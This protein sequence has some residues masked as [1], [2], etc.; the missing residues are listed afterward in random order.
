MISS[1]PFYFDLT[2]YQT[3]WLDFE[4]VENKLI[5]LSEIQLEEVKRLKKRNDQGHLYPK[6]TL[7][8]ALYIDLMFWANGQKVCQLGNGLFT[9]IEQLTYKP[10]NCGDR[11]TFVLEN[12]THF[13]A[14]VQLEHLFSEQRKK[15]AKM[16]IVKRKK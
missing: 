4:S 10:Y 9:D 5:R 16:K 8:I 13:Q 11:L 3:P 1:F 7:L 6:M 12:I 14:I 15:N 2:E